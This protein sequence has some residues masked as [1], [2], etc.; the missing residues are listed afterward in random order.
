MTIEAWLTD[1][2]RGTLGPQAGRVVHVLA[3]APQFAGYSSAREVAERAGVNVSTVVRT[4]QQLGFDGWPQLR[5]ELRARFSPR[6]PPETSPS[7]RQPTPRPRPCAR[8]PT[9]STRSPPPRRWTPSAPRRGP[10]KQPAAPSSSA[11]AAARAPLTSSATW[12]PSPATTS[13]SP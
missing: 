6:S 5:E 2:T 9:T 11:P 10:S 4:A 7:A 3:R 13:N 1:R 8:T 12:G